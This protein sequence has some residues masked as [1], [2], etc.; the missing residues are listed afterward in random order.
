MTFVHGYTYSQA[1]SR[2]GEIHDRLQQ[3]NGKHRLSRADTQE[4]AE[5]AK[6]AGSGGGG[7][8]R[9][10]PGSPQGSRSCYDRDPLGDP[11]DADAR[12]R[13]DPWDLAQVQ[14][15]GR[16]PRETAAELRSRALSAV[17]QMPGASDETRTTATQILEQHDTVDGKLSRHALITSNRDCQINGGSDLGIG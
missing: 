5:L 10:V 3:I 8:L 13:G 9:I 11:R 6:V 1:V 4:A 15:W 12:F 16:D 14:T 2:I 7:R 17:E